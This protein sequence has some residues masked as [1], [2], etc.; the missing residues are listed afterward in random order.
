MQMMTKR[1][2]KR[3][4]EM[5][6]LMEHDQAAKTRCL[7]CAYSRILVKSDQA[8]LDEYSSPGIVKEFHSRMELTIVCTAIGQSF[9][10]AEVSV[11]ELFEVCPSED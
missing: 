11:C 3:T 6:H 5:L 8:P 10:L 4:L 2:R 9:K 1:A 7:G